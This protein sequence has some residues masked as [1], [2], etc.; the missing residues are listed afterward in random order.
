MKQCTVQG[1]ENKFKAKGYCNTH[2]R[3]IMKYGEI[4]QKREKLKPGEKKEC[5]VDGCENIGTSK[6]MCLSHYG[7]Y[8]PKCIYELCENKSYICGFC[9]K[10]HRIVVLGIIPKPRKPCSVESCEQLAKCKGYCPKHY[11]RFKVH[12]DPLINYKRKYRKEPKI[13]MDNVLNKE[14]GAFNRLLEKEILHE[15]FDDMISIDRQEHYY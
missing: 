8:K 5:I 2:Y 12:G 14:R 15:I 1:C 9:K 3:H 13:Y 6:K 4:R 10:H 11:K 7:R